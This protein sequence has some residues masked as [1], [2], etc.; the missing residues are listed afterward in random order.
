M[1]GAAA[2]LGAFARLRPSLCRE[3]NYGR[4][5]HPNRRYLW[6]N[7][8][9]LGGVGAVSDDTLPGGKTYAAP[10]RCIAR[11]YDAGQGPACVELEA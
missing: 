1:A 9:L 3:R 6:Y 10:L 5:V 11:V 4:Y 8:V 2:G 7:E